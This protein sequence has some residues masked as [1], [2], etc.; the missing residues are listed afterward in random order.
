MIS[1]KVTEGNPTIQNQELH[2]VVLLVIAYV[3]TKSVKLQFLVRLSKRNDITP[4]Q[5]V[6]FLL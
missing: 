2:F 1:A 3:R 5:I 4:G 6:S